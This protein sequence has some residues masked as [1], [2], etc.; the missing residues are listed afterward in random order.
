[1]APSPTAEPPAATDPEPEPAPESTPT[2][3]PE[4]DTPEEEP[5]APAEPTGFEQGFSTDVAWAGPGCDC[6]KPTAGSGSIEVDQGGLRSFNQSLSGT[7]TAAGSGAYPYQLTHNASGDKHQL[8]FYLYT[9]EGSYGYRAEGSLVSRTDTPWGGWIY[10][11]EGTYVNTSR[12]A[13]LDGLPE[14]GGYVVEVGVSWT[15]DR[16]VSTSIFLHED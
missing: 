12:P 1:V 8:S 16:I 15:Q 5:S 10:R 7:A 2:S 9:S 11:Y 4:E 14:S 3:G 13:P 6:S